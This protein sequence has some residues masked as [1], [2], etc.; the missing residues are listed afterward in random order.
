MGQ[1]LQH[2]GRTQSDSKNLYLILTIA[3]KIGKGSMPPRSHTA[4]LL[5]VPAVAL[6]AARPS[7]KASV[8]AWTV[9]T[10]RRLAATCTMVTPHCTCIAARLKATCYWVLSKT[11]FAMH[12]VDQL[13]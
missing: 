5:A 7:E 10:S 11:C 12:A 8:T 3:Y 9:L 4:D 2:E 1:Q 13:K 6:W